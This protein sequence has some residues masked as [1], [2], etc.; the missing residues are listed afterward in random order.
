MYNSINGR[1]MAVAW[2]LQR[3]L[4]QNTCNILA[5][6]REDNKS[7]IQMNCAQSTN[8]TSYF[9]LQLPGNICV[10]INDKRHGKQIINT[11]LNSLGQNIYAVSMQRSNIFANSYL[12]YFWDSTQCVGWCWYFF[13]FTGSLMFEAR[14]K[15]SKRVPPYL[16]QCQGLL[17][18]ESPIP[19]SK[20]IFR[21]SLRRLRWA[22]ACVKMEIKLKFMS[23]FE[24]TI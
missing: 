13:H 24:I 16:T 3:H 19:A 6:G 9:R 18:I 22:K 17:L 7:G 1:K 8:S 14:L 4:Q 15:G 2:W 10:K 11:N 5:K 20:L 12:F 21:E 23:L